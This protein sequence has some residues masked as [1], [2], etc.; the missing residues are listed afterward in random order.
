ML[1]FS[2]LDDG[3]VYRHIHAGSPDAESMATIQAVVGKA[4][5]Q[6]KVLTLPPG[7]P[8]PPGRSDRPVQRDTVKR[9]IFQSFWSLILP[10]G[11]PG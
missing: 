7:V 6:Q 11:A 3:L 1:R 2:V 8:I 4:H 9:W 5:F 10:N